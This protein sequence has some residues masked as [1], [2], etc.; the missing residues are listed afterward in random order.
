MALS[1]D[2]QETYRTRL[3]EERGRIEADL[4][5]LDS[6][7]IDLGLS[8]Q[9]EGGGAGNHIADD[10]TDV[11]EQQRN[12][13]LIANLQDRMR[14]VVRSLER[15][16]EGTYGTCERCQKPIAPERLEALPFA[17]LCIACQSLEDNQRRP[18]NA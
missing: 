16:D 5:G 9:D 15:L 18:S 10:A 17:T 2:M 8:Q 14:D 7:M 6:E 13:A 1:T 3:I 4:A 11:M 12:L